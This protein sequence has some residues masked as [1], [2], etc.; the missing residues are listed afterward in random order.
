MSFFYQKPSML[1]VHPLTSP[2]TPTIKTK[3]KLD[4][5]IN[6]AS[7][8][9]SNPISFSIH[10]NRTNIQSDCHVPDPGMDNRDTKIN[11]TH[12][13]CKKLTASLLRRDAINTHLTENTPV[14]HWIVMR[15]KWDNTHE[16]FTFSSS[17]SKR[18]VFPMGLSSSLKDRFIAC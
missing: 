7:I 4:L 15:I 1:L 6:L 13:C 11:K 5:S 16:G 9:I 18:P 17:F 8:Y 10:L 3:P 14:P 12:S 2:V